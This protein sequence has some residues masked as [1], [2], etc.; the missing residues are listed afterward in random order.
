MV[1]IP[2]M[3]KTNDNLA[4][5]SLLPALNALLETRNVTRAAERI[6]VSQPA[7]SRIVAKLRVRFDDPLIVR[8][9]TQSQLT[10]RAEALRLPLKA[11]LEQAAQLVAA[12]QFNPETTDRL[13][14]LAIPDVVAAILL[15]PL[16]STLAVDA[17]NCTLVV[18]PWPGK[19]ADMSQF[20]IAV[21][22]DPEIFPG[23]RIEPLFE[24]HDV[25]AYRSTDTP[26]STRE[27]LRRSHVAVVPTGLTR[28]LAD[29]WLAGQGQ[30]RPIAVVVPHYLQALNLVAHSDLLAILPSRLVNA[31]GSAVGV[32]GVYLQIP[33]TP[34]RY[35]LP[36]PAHLT[37]DP[38]NQW[39]RHVVHHA[40]AQTQ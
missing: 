25:L 17:P 10:P 20:D 13:F 9:G 14:Y 27:A 23:F 39:I 8:T 37:S 30:T 11:I 24:D 5:L 19:N 26:P 36:Y 15:P 4:D 16:R 28:D 33:Q 38:A 29:E 40:S 31:T 18:A 35:W 22:A 12:P 3:Q 7:M 2:A 21:A 34:D 1:N 32:G 6:G